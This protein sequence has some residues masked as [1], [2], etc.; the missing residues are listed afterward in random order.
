MNFECLFCGKIESYHDADGVCKF[1]NLTPE[2]QIQCT[3]K[4]CGG[5][6]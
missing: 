5:V 3:N 6:F 1:E 4:K 2:A